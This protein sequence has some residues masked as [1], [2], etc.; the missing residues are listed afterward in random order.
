M[1]G[2]DDPVM[3]RAMRAARSLA[4]V[5]A[6]A[7]LS[8]MP[9]HAQSPALN[10][11]DAASAK[12]QQL[13]QETQPLNNQ[14]V[15]SE[16]RS[17]RGQVTQV[18]GRETNVLIQQGGQ[19]WR[20]LRNGQVAVYGGWAIVV[21]LVAIAAF[22]LWKGPLRLHSPMTG[23]KIRRFLPFQ[24]LIHWTTATAFAPP[25]FLPAKAPLAAM[26]PR[27]NTVTTTA[28]LMILRRFILRRLRVGA[29][30]GTRRPYG[31][32]CRLVAPGGAS[33]LPVL[34]TAPR[35]FAFERSQRSSAG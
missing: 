26:A 22:Y 8:A 29:L 5:V 30:D 28:R 13:Q 18:R 21:I 15:W 23:R 27:P 17:G 3:T 31:A 33:P 9:A 2:H 11:E 6:W 24:Q 19:T 25:F 12:A 7:A 35:R 10:A 34:A 14:P 1:A 32:P 20:A 4:V 16:V